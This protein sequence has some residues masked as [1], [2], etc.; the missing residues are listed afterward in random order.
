MN[1]WSKA[2][3]FAGASVSMMMCNVEQGEQ[4]DPL[5]DDALAAE[6]G[7]LAPA[8]VPLPPPCAPVSVQLTSG[9]NDNFAAGAVEVPTPSA[10]MQS[11]INSVYSIPGVRPYDAMHA[12]QYFAHTFTFAPPTTSHVLTGGTLLGR[13]IC[14]GSNDNFH[15]GLF[16]ATGFDPSQHWWAALNATPFNALCS[17]P[18]TPVAFALNLA[19]LPTTALSVIPG[20]SANGRL[21]VMMQ[22]DSAMDF[23]KLRLSYECNTRLP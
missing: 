14:G 12:N 23:L 10:A 4:G 8:A 21:D 19:N 6:E 15:L 20:M 11:W 1:Q 17:A 16:N 7:A 9:I 3:C 22:D 2:M 18:H 13:L 5:D